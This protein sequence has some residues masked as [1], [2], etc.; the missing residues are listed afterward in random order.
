MQEGTRLL[1]MLLRKTI[2]PFAR[3][4][5]FALAMLQPIAWAFAITENIFLLGWLSKPEIGE[6]FGTYHNLVTAKWL[7]ALAG[8]FTAIIAIIFRKRKHYLKNN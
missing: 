8:A 7:I 2:K 5:L 4:V 3:N 1:C 6:E